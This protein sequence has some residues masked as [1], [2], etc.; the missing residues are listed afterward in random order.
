MLRKA[1]AA[2]GCLSVLSVAGLASSQPSLVQTPPVAMRQPLSDSDSATLMT[3]LQAA[4]RDDGATIRSLLSTL[5]DPTARRIAQWALADAAPQSM[6]FMEIDAARRDLAG[7]PRA[8]A[9]QQAAE[10][11]IE[12]SGMGPQAIVTWFGGG[13]PTTGEGAMALASALQATGHRTEAND[14]I[15]V[16]WRTLSFEADVQ[17]SMLARFGSVLTQE[18]H[19]RRLD[20]LL[21]GPQGPAARDMLNLVTGDQR[22]LGDARMALRSNSGNAMGLAGALPSSVARDPGLIVEQ[23]GYLRRRGQND[24]ALS[25]LASATA[26]TIPSDEAGSRIWRE[27]YQLVLYAL[28]N[29]NFRGAYAAAANTGLTRGGDAADAEFYAGWIAL[30][31]LRDPA[32]ADTHFARLQSIG[33]SPITQGRALYWRG[34][35]A[36]AANDAVNAQLYYG[37]AARFPTVF[38]GQL[39]AAK[40]GQAPVSLGR[41]PEVTS[42]D[43]AR[44]EGREAVRAAR[45]LAEIGARDTFKVLVQ[46]IDDIL[47]TAAEEALLVDL[48]RGYGDQDLSMKVVRAAAQRGFLLPDRGYPVR[49]APASGFNGVETALV[50]GVTRQESGFDP[51]ARSP[52]GARG[53]MQLMPGTAQILAR[54]IGISYNGNLLDDPE[55][56]MRLGSAYLSQMIDTFSGS[57]VMAIAAYNAGPN[58]PSEW[59][60]FC[61]D[62]RG[63]ATDPIDFIECIPFSETRNYVMRV[64]EGMQVYRF[65]LNG[66]TAPV[67]IHNDLRRGAYGYQTLGPTAA[68]TRSLTPATP[69][70][71]MAPIPD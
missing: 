22:A 26:P 30:T 54:R 58:R 19:V 3:I 10:K 8:A 49:S 31:R 6:S 50:Y 35:A 53:L 23:V 1:L 69:T 45:M 48:A 7:W 4:Q 61:G 38:Y 28:R 21:Y 51:R 71:G 64:M 63:G 18:D 20:M 37:Q 32:R 40:L 2:L 12:T 43:R 14:T 13:T 9:R 41:D 59:S 34:R 5:R 17:R 66:G 42:A 46:S 44:F 62:P 55:Y 11:L 33:S 57:Y 68:P 25:I 52:V 70:G 67:T 27:R 65:K 39:A 60:T 16:A 29:R 36:E 24:Q 15:R 56:N 47:P